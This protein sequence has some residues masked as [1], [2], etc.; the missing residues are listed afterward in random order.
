MFQ[1]VD[2]EHDGVHPQ[3][4]DW[5]DSS[6]S[7]SMHPSGRQSGGVPGRLA[8]GKPIVVKDTLLIDDSEH[9]DFGNISDIVDI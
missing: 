4:K 7:G 6:I 9:S 2:H 1:N 8:V 5:W 3:A